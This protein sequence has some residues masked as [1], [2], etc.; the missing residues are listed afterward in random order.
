M[1]YVADPAKRSLGFALSALPN[2]ILMLGAI[3]G[4]ARAALLL[5]G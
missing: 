1:S 4:A 5:H 2:I 3:F